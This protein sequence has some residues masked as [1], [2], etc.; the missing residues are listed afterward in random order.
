MKEAW[1]ANIPKVTAYLT[2]KQT[3]YKNASTPTG[4]YNIVL[5]LTGNKDLAEDAR[6]KLQK[7]LLEENLGGVTVE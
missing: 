7:A 1:I 3:P 2:K 5:A 4:I 6:T